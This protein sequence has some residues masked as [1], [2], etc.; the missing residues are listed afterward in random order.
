[1]GLSFILDIEALSI[2]SARAD[3]VY[4]FVRS[5]GYNPRSDSFTPRVLRE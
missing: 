2:T 3:F 5:I 1:V 4:D